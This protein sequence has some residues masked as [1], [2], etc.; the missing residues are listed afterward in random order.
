MKL[1]HFLCLGLLL[2]LLSAPVIMSVSDDPIA[3]ADELYAKRNNQEYVYQAISLLKQTITLTPD[4]NNALWRLARCYWYL[5]DHATGKT[6]L[7]LFAEGQDYAEKAI[8][9]NSNEI[10]GHYWYAA[11]LGAAGEAR[12]IFQSLASIAP[13]KKELDICIRID[14]KF[15]DAHDVLAQLFWKAP[16]PPLS[17]GN[18]KR[19][20]EESKLA[21]SDGPD[22]IEYLLHLGQIARDNKDYLKARESFRQLL[23]LPD[24]PEDPES[25]QSDKAIAV[26]ELKKLENKK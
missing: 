6:K 7:N 2:M 9:A 10:H 5:G 24:D 8:K 11:L 4:N 14:A 18:K 21:V 20:L 22:N 17:I 25:S 1:S 26:L 13:M 23:T 16:G 15:A 3:T 19:A 12:G